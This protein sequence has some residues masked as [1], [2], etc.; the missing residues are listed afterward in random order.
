MPTNTKNKEAKLPIKVRNDLK[1]Q[2]DNH[3]QVVQEL[4]RKKLILLG[5]IEQINMMLGESTNEQ[6]PIH[7]GQDK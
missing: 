6:Q 7:P 1:K 3:L 2:R 4:E 5:A